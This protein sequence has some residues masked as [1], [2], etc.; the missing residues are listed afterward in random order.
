[1]EISHVGTVTHFYKPRRANK[2]GEV[3]PSYYIIIFSSTEL[4]KKNKNSRG[5]N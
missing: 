5:L 2:Y 1:M 4:T 3:G